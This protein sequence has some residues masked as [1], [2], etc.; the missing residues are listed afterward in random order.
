MEDNSN[1]WLEG[2]IRS[3]RYYNSGLPHDRLGPHGQKGVTKRVFA[4]GG[5]NAMHAK[6][7]KLKSRWSFNE[8]LKGAHFDVEL[9][10]KI[11]RDLMLQDD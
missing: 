10:G 3:W 6:G 4:G 8:S 5:G 9:H 1:V 7:K 11:Q 2:L